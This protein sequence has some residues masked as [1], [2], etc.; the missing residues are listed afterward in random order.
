VPHLEDLKRSPGQIIRSSDWNRLVDEVQATFPS[1]GGYLY[2]NVIPSPDL[3][4][5][6]GIPLKRWGQ[7]HAGY[8]YFTYSVSAYRVSA[9]Y[10]RFTRSISTYSIRAD[11]GR[12]SYPVSIMKGKIWIIGTRIHYVDEYG[13]E[14]SIEGGAV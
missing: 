3:A 7:V 8:G 12:F 1:A 10:G 6:L 14:R 2:G 4:L 13:T 11:Y 9:D 5:K